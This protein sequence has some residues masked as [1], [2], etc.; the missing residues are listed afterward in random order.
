MQLPRSQGQEILHLCFL[1]QFVP[2]NLCVSALLMALKQN[3]VAQR[4][5]L[6]N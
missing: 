4:H 2:I 1:G 3:L 5:D 6:E